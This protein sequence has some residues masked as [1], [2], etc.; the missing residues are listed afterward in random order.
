MKP[1]ELCYLMDP[2]LACFEIYLELLSCWR[3]VDCRVLTGCWIRWPV[4]FWWI[5]HVL[6]G[7]KVPAD[8]VFGLEDVSRDPGVVSDWFSELCSSISRLHCG[9]IHVS[10]D[11]SSSMLIQVGDKSETHGD[12]AAKRGRDVESQG[13]RG[14]RSHPRQQARSV[15]FVF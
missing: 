5:W 7:G 12:G 3:P 9:F 2:N 14:A 6:R 15:K 1:V 11:P 8:S 4:R 13:G 10:E